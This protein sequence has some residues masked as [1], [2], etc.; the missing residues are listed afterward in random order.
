MSE[1]EF[2]ID[3]NQIGFRLQTLEILN[4]G[5]FHNQIW[6]IEP[7]G[8][9]SLLTGD[10]GSG[11]STLV[12]ALTCLIVPHHKITFNK[13]AGAESKERTLLSYIRGEYKNTK[14][15]EGDSREKAVT[16]RYSNPED[17]TFSVIIA[18]FINKGYQSNVALA[19]VFWI[20]NDKAQKLLIIR[21]KN[22]LSIKEH[23]TNI[24]DVKSLRKRLKELSHIELFDDNFSKYSQRFR[25][26]FGMNSDKAIDL[27]YQT[28]SMKSVS[29]LTSFVREQMLERTEIKAQIDDLKKRFDDLNKAYAAVQQARKQKDILSPLIKLSESFRGFQDSISNIDN[30]LQSLPSFFSYKKQSILESE[31]RSCERRLQQLEGQLSSID[32]QLNE[33]RDTITDLKQNIRE[34]GGSRLE[35]I[36]NDL[37][38]KS[39]L[40]DKKRKV[41]K[42][43][44]DLATISGLEQSNS[45]TSFFRNLKNAEQKIEDLKQRHDDILGEHGSLIG[46]K[47]HIT[48][49]IESDSKE[50]ESLKSRENQIPLEFLSLRRTLANDLDIL[51]DE[52]PFAGE[53]M[54]VANNEKEWEGALEKLLRGF[55][56]SMLVPEKHYR[57]VSQYVNAKTLRDRNK[58]LK[59]DYFPV[60]Y[61]FSYRNSSIDIDED[62]VVNKIE[63]KPNTNFEEWLQN[64]LEVH[65]NLRC[66]TLEEF[67]QQK[68]DVMTKEGQMKKGKKHTK[69]DR[70]D[71]WDRKNFVLGWTNHDKIL[72]LQKHLNE[73][74]NNK[75]EIQEEIDNLSTELKKN[76]ELQG[77]LS[78][79]LAYK[80]WF[81]LNWQD[82]VTTIN[83]LE[84]ERDDLQN[85]N[86]ILKT[87]NKRL[88]E[89][90]KE[91]KE[92]EGARSKADQE[93]GNLDG[94]LNEYYADVIECDNMVDLLSEDER[95]KYFPVLETELNGVELTIKNIV[96]LRDD[97]HKQKTNQR[98]ETSDKQNGVRD[99]IIRQ[100]KEYND[101]FPSDTLDVTPEIESLP[102][103]LWKF[104]KIMNEG[105]PA[106]EATLKTMLNKNTID[107]IVAFDNKLDIHEKSIKEKI[108]NIN[109]H[110]KAIEFNKGTYIELIADRNKDIEI[111]RFRDDLKA[112]Y[113][114]ILDTND[115]YTEDRFNDVQK[116]LNR[117]RGNESK[118][119][120][121]TNKVTDVRN[122]FDFNAMERYIADNSE[123]EFYA[124][125]SGKSGGQKEKLAYTII[126]SALAYQFGLTYGEPRSRSFRFAVI[127]EAFGKGSDS[128]AEYGLELFKKLN[129]QLLIVT[130][131]QKI[132]IIENYIKSVHYVSN[133]EGNNS[134][135]QNL[136]VEEY[137]AEKLLHNVPTEGIQIKELVN[138][139][140]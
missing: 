95:E 91:V 123:K 84:K 14:N 37:R 43:Y 2:N 5:T 110:L 22:S 112:C 83:Q 82:E 70:R 75:D 76:T 71:L 6:K 117:F 101:Q 77:K 25:Q 100:M 85:S 118:D 40:R 92:L 107:D 128:S 105:L 99:K 65:F 94:K 33:K 103:Y 114:N 45:E 126:A 3:N 26:L 19:Q 115:A 28:V 50:L 10:V 108:K 55:G 4:W 62:S 46:I 73:L 9:N 48:E 41:H 124:G 24:E 18:N 29:S 17:A 137:K 23:F 111:K 139:N 135:I 102:E 31:I 51:E 138:G 121:W 109:E 59:L 132:H 106:H 36:A 63:I 35:Q 88:E 21:E 42:E 89:V 96:K 53:L 119:V 97:L 47:S 52:I 129:L 134:E 58:G 27:F 116:I 20:E 34:N 44:T 66:V 56:I 67:Q 54:K 8:N 104:E 15:E 16:L 79:L 12:D 86:D 81:D 98:K 140:A 68:R 90:N 130:P 57:V 120:E 125:S 131:L 64:E 1:L 122:W 61:N 39:E 78:Q 38:I 74:R 60:P 11:K 69:D 49:E 13:A 136:S 30:I 7:D 133:T 87:L 93:K 72:A 113:S 80:N 32:S 127:D